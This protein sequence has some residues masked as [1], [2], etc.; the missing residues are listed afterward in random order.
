MPS[1]AL[2]Q[3]LGTVSS[4]RLRALLTPLLIVW[5]ALHGE[6]SLAED[7]P[8]TVLKVIPTVTKEQN[9]HNSI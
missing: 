4:S 8:H 6:G 9:V 7:L 3:N 2:P 1:V 5:C